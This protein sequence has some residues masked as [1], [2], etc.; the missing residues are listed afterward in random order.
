MRYWVA[1]AK[2]IRANP[3]LAYPGRRHRV[4]VSARAGH[5]PHPRRAWQCRPLQIIARQIGRTY[6]EWPTMRFFKSDNTA[7]VSAEILAAISGVNHGAAL[8]Y[9]ADQWSER[10]DAVFG[11]FFETRVRVFA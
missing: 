11:E 1:T 7:A 5:G 2:K 10:L 3:G 8:A 9:G 6:L 4:H